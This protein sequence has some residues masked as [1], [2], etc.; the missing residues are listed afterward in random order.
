MAR[1]NKLTKSGSGK[2][3]AKTRGNVHPV[4]LLRPMRGGLR[5]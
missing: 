5:L 1:R 2:L 3:F 4:N